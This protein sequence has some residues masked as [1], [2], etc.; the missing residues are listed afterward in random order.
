MGGVY[1]EDWAEGDVDYLADHYHN[2]V[3][4]FSAAARNRQAV[5]VALA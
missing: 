1:P 2:L 3:A 5:V 4:F